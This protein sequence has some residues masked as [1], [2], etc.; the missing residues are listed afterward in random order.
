MISL[1][2]Y[3][4]FLKK[5]FIQGTHFTFKRI[6]EDFFELYKSCDRIRAGENDEFKLPQSSC[7]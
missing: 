1:R 7:N 6:Y 5:P 4:R 3:T 2:S